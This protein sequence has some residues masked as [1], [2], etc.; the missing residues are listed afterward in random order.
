MKRRIG[1]AGWTGLG[2]GGKSLMD[3]IP[4]GNKKQDALIKEV[5]K[6]FY[7][8]FLKGTEADYGIC[9]AGTKYEGRAIM[10]GYEPSYM[11]EPLKVV[12]IDSDKERSYI[13]TGYAFGGWGT[14]IRSKKSTI[15]SLST[16]LR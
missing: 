6:E 8:E 2:G 4:T 10:L 1:N 15:K 16:N 7:F 5:S 14:G 3:D 12:L 9:D 13:M 11:Y